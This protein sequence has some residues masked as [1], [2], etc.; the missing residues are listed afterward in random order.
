MLCLVTLPFAEFG[1]A[2]KMGEIW[3]IATVMIV[4]SERVSRVVLS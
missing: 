4:L 2:A 3:K 1:E